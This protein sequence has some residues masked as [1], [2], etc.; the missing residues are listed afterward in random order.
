MWFGA[1]YQPWEYL[2]RCVWRAWD[3]P[4]PSP[5]HPTFLQPFNPVVKE[6]PFGPHGMVTAICILEPRKHEETG[7]QN[8]FSAEF[9]FSFFFF[10]EN[11]GSLELVMY[12]LMVSCRWNRTWGCLLSWKSFKCSFQSH[13]RVNQ[14]FRTNLCGRWTYATWECELGIYI[15]HFSKYR[16]GI[17]CSPTSK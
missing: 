13:R 3:V 4:S 16:C 1:H 6:L 14:K 5:S 11:L 15:F 2:W 10:H 8:S 7:D 12:G 9:S 17:I